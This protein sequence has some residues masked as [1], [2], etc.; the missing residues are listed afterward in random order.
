MSFVDYIDL[1]FLIIDLA[2]IIIYFK[3]IVKYI[4]NVIRRF[5]GRKQSYFLAVGISDKFRGDV[6][7][8]IKNSG[9]SELILDNGKNYHY[10]KMPTDDEGRVD[11]DKIVGWLNKH[12]FDQN[13]MNNA[14]NAKQIHVFVER[15]NYIYAAVADILLRRFNCKI[16]F[17]KYAYSSYYPLPPI[18]G[19]RGSNND[20]D[21]TS[22]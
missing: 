17:Y 1:F 13:R 21:N 2:A 11:R 10:I 8:Y 5:F 20:T 9:L 14:V 7:A 18:K 22:N 6:N 15:P 12:L 3:F 16:I 4:C 19:K